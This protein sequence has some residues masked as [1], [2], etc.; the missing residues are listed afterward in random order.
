[1]SQARSTNVAGAT[2]IVVEVV[3]L[4]DVSLVAAWRVPC[5]AHEATRTAAESAPNQLLGDRC[6]GH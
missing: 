1:M 4:V 6:I 2:A 3:V 5:A